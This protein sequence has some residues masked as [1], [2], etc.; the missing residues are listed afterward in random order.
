MEKEIKPLI[1]KRAVYAV[2]K[3]YW[4]QY[5]RWPFWTIVAILAPSVGSVFVFYVPPLIIAKLVNIIT[6][7]G[8]LTIRGVWFQI[9]LF[10]SLWGIGELLWRIGRHFM[11]K[12]DTE[13]MNSLSKAA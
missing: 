8:T 10:A 6:T 3:A 12:L 11:I 5:K 4:Q 1:T 7:G 13:G 2:L 9:F